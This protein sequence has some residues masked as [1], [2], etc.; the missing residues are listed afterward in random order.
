MART[1]LCYLHKTGAITP[2]LRVV[3]CSSRE[4]LPDA[5]MAELRSW[6]TFEVIDVYDDED[7]RLFSFTESPRLVN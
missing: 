6:G 1:F 7:H 3:A 2:E 4:A 5:I